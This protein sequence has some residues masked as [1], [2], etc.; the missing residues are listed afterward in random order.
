MCYTIKCVTI[1]QWIFIVL[2]IATIIILFTIRFI[3][4]NKYYSN[5][6]SLEEASYAIS[7]PWLILVYLSTL[8][9]CYGIF[10]L[11]KI[12]KELKENNHNL[13][14]NTIQIIIHCGLLLV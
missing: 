13:K 5:I 11:V 6:F 4:L 3:S 12:V 14:F 2:Y 10:K 8:V 1:T 7:V 9:T